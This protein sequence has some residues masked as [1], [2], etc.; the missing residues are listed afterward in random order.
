MNVLVVVGDVSVREDVVR[1]FENIQEYYPPVR[2]IFHAAGVAGFNLL[3]DI[4]PQ[5]LQ[6]LLAPKV[7]GTW[8]LHQITLG[9]KLD[10]FVC[11]SSITSVWGSDGLS[12][13]TAANHF[14]DIFAHYRHSLNLPALTVNV[15]ALKDGG[16]HYRHDQPTS[17]RERVTQIGLRYYSPHDLLKTLEYSLGNG[18][19]QQIIIDIDWTIF[20]GIYEVRERRT[21][22]K[23][24]QVR[25]PKSLK[26]LLGR[27][28]Y[29]L[30]KLKDAYP[31]DRYD[32]LLTYVQDKIALVLKLQN[33]QL[34]TP[35]QNLMEVGMDSLTAIELKNSIQTELGVDIPI[36]KFMEG[37]TVAILTNELNRKLNSEDWELEIEFSQ[38]DK[39]SKNNSS[40]IEG[41]I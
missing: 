39:V 19:A 8:N 6:S 12:H 1:I 25:S 20:K 22:L 5:L 34:P 11:I 3:P 27:M 13:Y 7:A 38:D 31:G 40:W 23:E 21:L 14:L 29:L 24:I 37:I 33:F 30:H 16:M 17:I 4:T 18:V 32:I 26:P 9:M 41:E 28:E 2:G 10:F 15:G 36:V 35:E